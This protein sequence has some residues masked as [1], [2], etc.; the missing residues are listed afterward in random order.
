M[1]LIM[2]Q[3]YYAAPVLKFRLELYHQVKN[4]LNLVIKCQFWNSQLSPLTDLFISEE[5]SAV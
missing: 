2:P 3:C 5:A 1:G 4:E